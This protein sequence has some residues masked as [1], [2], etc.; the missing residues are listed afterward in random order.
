MLILAAVMMVKIRAIKE[1][2]EKNPK[3]KSTK[4]RLESWESKQRKVLKYL[5]RQ[6]SFRIDYRI[7]K[8]L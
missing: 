4:R 7:F 6:V 5:K 8:S 3:D 1:H 2:L